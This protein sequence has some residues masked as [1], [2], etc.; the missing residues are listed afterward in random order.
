MH[1]IQTPIS[2][3]CLGNKIPNS[4][5]FVC[6]IYFTFLIVSKLYFID[7]RLDIMNGSHRSFNCGCAVGC[8][9][10]LNLNNHV[11]DIVLSAVGVL[12]E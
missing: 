7:M 10:D 9:V 12:K 5:C 8:A 3:S 2:K 4:F 1:W 11:F 6:F